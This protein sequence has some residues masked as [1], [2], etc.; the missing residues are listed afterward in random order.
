MPMAIVWNVAQRVPVKL[1]QEEDD[2]S[3]SPAANDWDGR[4]VTSSGSS[5]SSLDEAVQG[6]V[7]G[8]S[9]SSFE[10]HARDIKP[11]P[12]RTRK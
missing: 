1:I 7:G 11:I 12:R 2:S 5:D 3:S 8:D 9:Y 6:R 10:Q 4:I